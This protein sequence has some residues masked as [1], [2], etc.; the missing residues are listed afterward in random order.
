MGR[1]LTLVA[2]SLAPLCSVPLLSMIAL[3]AAWRLRLRFS[4]WQYIN[5]S[6]LAL[7]FMGFVAFVALYFG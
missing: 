6:L 7:S 3:L 4:I 2:M 5:V 1:G